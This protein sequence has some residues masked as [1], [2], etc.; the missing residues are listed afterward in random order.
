MTSNFMG[1]GDTIFPT[2]TG[3]VGRAVPGYKVKIVDNEGKNVPPN[4]F[5]KSSLLPLLTI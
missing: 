3:S 1:I 2:K 4:T 5:G